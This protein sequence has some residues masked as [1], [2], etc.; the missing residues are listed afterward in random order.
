VWGS[1]C[2]GA[3]LLAI[4]CRVRVT[5]WENVEKGRAVGAVRFAARTRGRVWQG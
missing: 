3:V 1:K 2:T 4:G 5:G